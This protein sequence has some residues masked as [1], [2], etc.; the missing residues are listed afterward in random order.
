MI[1]RQDAVIS[2]LLA[3]VHKLEHETN[4]YSHDLGDEAGLLK[5]KSV[6]A[7]RA[8]RTARRGELGTV[9]RIPRPSLKPKGR[10]CDLS[11]SEIRT[12]R[13]ASN[14]SRQ[15]GGSAKLTRSTQRL[16][17]VNSA[18][19]ESNTSTL[20]NGAKSEAFTPPFPGKPR[21]ARQSPQRAV[22][23]RSPPTLGS[24]PDSSQM[25]AL[26]ESHRTAS[27]HPHRLAERVLRS[28]CAPR[29]ARSCSPPGRVSMAQEQSTSFPLAPRSVSPPCHTSSLRAASLGPDFQPGALTVA[30]TLAAVAKATQA[31]AAVV[32]AINRLRFERDMELSPFSLR[33][34]GR[35][36]E[37]CSNTSTG[38]S[39][40]ADDS[41]PSTAGSG[42]RPERACVEEEHV[43]R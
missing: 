16:P 20:S 40:V 11:I 15:Y 7:L 22:W 1:E 33:K 43:E 35:E 10:T 14:P 4:T 8:S 23:R 19:I 32:P 36:R 30:A 18:N 41:S 26:V 5:T 24:R 17:I 39:S 34:H 2:S 25:S 38:A 6:G 13:A 9:S 42:L 29:H 28:S 12:Q 37:P 3:R 21:G 27:K 31:A